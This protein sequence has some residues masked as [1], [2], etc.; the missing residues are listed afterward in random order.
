MFEFLAPIIGSVAGALISNEGNNDAAQI[1][2]STA[3]KQIAALNAAYDKVSPYLKR[4][5]DVQPG[6]I[7]YLQQVMAT[8]ANPYK[9]TPAQKIEMGDRIRIAKEMT[10]LSIRGS[11]RATSAIINDVAN[12]GRAAMGAQNQARADTAANTLNTTGAQGANNLA[13]LATGNASGTV[14][15]LG[16]AGDV[17]ANAATANASNT[18]STL[19]Q[20]GGFFADYLKNQERNSRFGNSGTSVGE[21]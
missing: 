8:G 15:A 7:D 12:R 17:A 6:A 2:Q 11:G 10:P 18:A 9:L 20:L 16:T 4:S 19:G 5:A 13:N 21:S 3:D 14:S 1:A